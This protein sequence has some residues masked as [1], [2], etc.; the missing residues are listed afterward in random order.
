MANFLIKLLGVG[1]D[2]LL[3]ICD[4]IVAWFNFSKHVFAL[5]KL[6]L[7]MLPFDLGVKEGDELRTN[8]YVMEILRETR[9]PRVRGAGEVTSP[10]TIL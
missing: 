4:A 10:E 9:F 2:L 3:R 5:D 7:Y 8:S 6:L 1:E